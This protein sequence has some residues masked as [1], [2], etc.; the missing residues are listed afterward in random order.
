[1]ENITLARMWLTA[2]C[3]C[4][5]MFAGCI[6]NERYQERA[7]KEASIA[8]G[9]NATQTSCAWSRSTTGECV[10]LAAQGK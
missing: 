8:K 5:A 7:F 1:M 4:V 3:V 6:A 10:V 9:M 2:T